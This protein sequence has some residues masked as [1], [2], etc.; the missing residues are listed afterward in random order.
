MI[1]LFLGGPVDGQMRNVDKTISPMAQSTVE[2][3][4]PNGLIV[5]YHVHF[6]A[7]NTMQFPVA[8]FEGTTADDIFK[9]LLQWYSA[10]P[11]VRPASIVQ[12]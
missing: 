3:V 11:R 6:L 7:G 9:M 10:K 1:L 4:Q 5:R 2:I 12:S 8:C